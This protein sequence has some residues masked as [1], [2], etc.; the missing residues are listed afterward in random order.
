LESVTQAQGTRTFALRN[1]LDRDARGENSLQQ[2]P[3]APEELQ[4]AL[5]PPFL[6]HVPGVLAFVVEEDA[7][8]HVARVGA[9]AAQRGA[10]GLRA[11]A[12]K[13]GPRWGKSK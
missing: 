2:L 5:L 1:V 6:G 8:V 10:E 3:D 11:R 7:E 12:G 4:L 13:A 9:Q